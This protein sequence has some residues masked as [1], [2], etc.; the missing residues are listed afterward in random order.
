MGPVGGSVMI[1][2]EYSG[3]SHS[4]SAPHLVMSAGVDPDLQLATIGGAP[5]LESHSVMSVDAASEVPAIINASTGG[6]LPL[7]NGSEEDQPLVTIQEQ[8]LKPEHLRVREGIPGLKRAMRPPPQSQ[9]NVRDGDWK[10]FTVAPVH[11]FR[12]RAGAIKISRRKHPDLLREYIHSRG[13]Q[14]LA[15]R[16]LIKGLVGKMVC[17]KKHDFVWQG[18]PRCAVCC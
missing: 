12:V 9:Y 7:E 16:L 6:H 11:H 4:G 15:R 10:T 5:G 14:P 3:A 18:K 13:T 17:R 1:T 2:D 8:F